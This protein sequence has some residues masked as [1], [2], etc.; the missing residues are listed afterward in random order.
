MLCSSNFLLF[1]L[2]YGAPTFCWTSKLF[3]GKRNFGQRMLQPR[4]HPAGEH[5]LISVWYSPIKNVSGA[6]SPLSRD[7]VSGSKRSHSPTARTKDPISCRAE[8]RPVINIYY[9][10]QPFSVK[11]ETQHE[12][13]KNGRIFGWKVIDLCDSYVV[14]FLVLGLETGCSPSFPQCDFPH[15]YPTWCGGV[16]ALTLHPYSREFERF[17]KMETSRKVWHELLKKMTIYTIS[18]LY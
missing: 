5:Q 8:S 6:L 17:V 2:I 13:L 4:L 11:N 12:N 1:T 9:I 15:K 18:E 16:S 10:W 14:I 7:T 3:F